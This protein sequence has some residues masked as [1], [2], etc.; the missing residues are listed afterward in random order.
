VRNP[1]LEAAII[2]DPKDDQL[3]RVYADWLEE[4]DDPRAELIRVQLD[5]G[6]DAARDLLEERGKKML[7]PALAK[8]ALW[9]NWERG[10]VTSANL[11]ERGKIVA[12]PCLAALLASPTSAFLESLEIYTHNPAPVIKAL[13]KA[14]STLRYL[15]FFSPTKVA[16]LKNVAKVL[17]RQK[18]LVL[19]GK[20]ELVDPLDLPIADEVAIEIDALSENSAAI[21]ASANLPRVQGLTLG[22]VECPDTHATLAPLF[23]RSMPDL[24]YLVITDADELDDVCELL[25]E[26]PFA[27][28]LKYLEIAGTLTRR[29]VEALRSSDRLTKLKDLV[30]KADI[31]RD[32]L[33]TLKRKGRKVERYDPSAE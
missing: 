4:Q 2:A 7:G 26:A 3:Y 13:P 16:T 5:S 1:E 29:G 14:P 31:D 17:A 32:L 11:S 19:D 23:A 28:Q 27:K 10:F 18:K 22:L 6:D 30:V 15:R 21:V 20:F 9:L 33:G 8:Y 25:A 12:G 24:D